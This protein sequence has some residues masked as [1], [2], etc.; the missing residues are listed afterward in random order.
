MCNCIDFVIAW[1]DGSDPVWLQEKEKY[2]GIATA[3]EES[4]FRDWGLLRFWFRGVERFAPWVNKIHFITFGHLPEWLDIR[5][6]KI[7]I[8][9]HKDFIPAKYLPTFNSHTI[10]LNFHRVPGLA[11][12]FVYFNDDMFLI[13]H[14][15]PDDF[16]QNGVP[17][18]TCCLDVLHFTSNSAS[19]IDSNNIALLNDRFSKKDFVHQNF[20]KLFTPGVGARKFFKNILLLPFPF[21]TG[22]F[23]HH[24]ASSFLKNSYSHAWEIFPEQLD[25]SCCCKLRNNSNI[26][27][28]LIKDLQ[29]IQGCFINRE[30]NF[31]KRFNL[32]EQNVE[33]CC[34]FIQQQKGKVLC[35]NDNEKLKDFTNVKSEV[36]HAFTALLPEKSKFENA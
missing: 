24:I 3:A 34:K 35:I 10:E 7:H 21:F 14:V 4:R 9:N 17:K 20:L 36:Q 26:N 6:P 27:Q 2:C 19:F 12:Q 1:V 15:N 32:T 11:E 13:N 18:E 22:F 16:F 30:I 8:V 33:E 23:N 5:H 25:S 31:G 28:W 29:F